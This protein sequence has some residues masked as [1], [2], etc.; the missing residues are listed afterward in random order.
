MMILFLLIMKRVS[1]ATVMLLTL[2]AAGRA[3]ANV[4]VTRAMGDRGR[5]DVSIVDAPL[6]EAVH[7]LEIYLGR[8]VAIDMK[9]APRVTVLANGVSPEEALQLVADV[10]RARLTR[11]HDYR[12]SDPEEWTASLD[13]KDEKVRDVLK[14]LQKQCGVKNLIVDPDVQGEATF[15]FRE[16][17]CHTAFQ[18]VFNVFGLGVFTDTP[19]VLAVGKR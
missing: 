1:I 9:K 10:A 14:S 11:G 3:S 15:L 12:L 5:L 2:L 19:S 16:V 17:P 4:K 18:T 8:F 6:A 13:V 7:V